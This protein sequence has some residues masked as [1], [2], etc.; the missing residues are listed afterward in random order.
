MRKYTTP[1]ETMRGQG[2]VTAQGSEQV[3]ATVEYM[4]RVTRTDEQH[5]R[6]G[7]VVE[8][9]TDTQGTITLAEGDY[10]EAGELFTLHLKDGRCADFSI[11]HGDLTGPQGIQDIGVSGGI[12]DC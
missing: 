8:G 9:V 2:T 6:T 7:E 1:V 3:I 12:R 10:L 11:T 4:L 5:V